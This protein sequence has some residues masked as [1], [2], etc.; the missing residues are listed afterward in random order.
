MNVEIRYF[1]GPSDWGWVQQH[2]NLK[3]VED[4]CGLVAIDVEQNKTIGAAIFDNFIHSAATLTL[5]METPLLIRHGFL[6]EAYDFLFHGCKKK[7]CYAMVAAN[8]PRSIKL[9]EHVGYC[10]K[11]RIPD[12]FKPGVDFIVYELAREDFYKNKNPLKEVA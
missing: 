6:D 8:N 7:Y 12:G 11:M 1:N 3:R 2:V 4:T 5:I 9:T 10:E